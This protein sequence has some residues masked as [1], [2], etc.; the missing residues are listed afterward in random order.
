MTGPVHVFAHGWYGAGNVGDELLLDT[1]AR[2]TEEA[3]ATLSVASI[4]PAHT[5]RMHGL[6]AVHARDLAAV[7]RRM[8]ASD[9]VVLGG[10][11]LFQTHHAF[12]IAGLYSFGSGDIAAYARPA[13]MAAQWGLP[14]LLWAQG[15]GPLEG[16]QARRIVAHVASTAHAVS[17][18]DAESARLLREIGVARETVVAPDPVW[19]MP[20]GEAPPRNGSLQRLGL[21]IRPWPEPHWEA[22]LVEAL[23]AALDPAATTLA[24]IAFQTADSESDAP[25]IERLQARLPMFRHETV[26]VRE[27]DRAAAEIAACDALVCMRLHAQIL[28]LRLA[29]PLLCL[30]YDAKM[31]VTSELAGVPDA[32]RLTLDAPAAAWVAKMRGLGASMRSPAEPERLAR[33]SREA[34]HHREVLHRAIAD[35]AER[36][37]GRVWRESGFDWAAAWSCDASHHAIAQREGRIAALAELNG[38][39]ASEIARLE[40]SLAASRAEVDALRLDRDAV[41]ACALQLDDELQLLRAM[42]DELDACLARSRQ[43]ADAATM[44]RLAAE[45]EAAQLSQA[46]QATQESMSWRITHPLRVARGLLVLRG[47]ARRE[48]AISAARSLFWSL[49]G[50]LR[51][52]A[53]RVRRHRAQSRPAHARPAGFDWPAWANAGSRIAIVPSA[54]EFDELVNQRPI[55][56][57]KYLAARGVHVVFAAW[58]WRRDEVLQ[59]SGSEVYPGVMQVDLYDLL[60]RIGE[61]N[62]RADRESLYV[63]TLPAPDLVRLHAAARARGLAVVYDIL[64]DW[65]GFHA[66]GQAPWFDDAYEAEAVLAADV[67]A[68]VSPALAARFASLRGDIEVIGNGHTPALLGLE[69]RLCARRKAP[70]TR[71]RIGYFG[72]LTEA[73]FD[74]DVVLEAARRLPDMDFELIGYGE[75]EW[76]RAATAALPNVTLVGKVPPASLWRY[77]QQWDVALAPF[78]PGPLAECID[79]IKAYEYLYFGLPVVC[80]GIAHLA[81]FPGVRVVQGAQAFIEACT[82]LAEA[83]PDTAR[84]DA[85]LQQ[86]TWEARFDRLLALAAGRGLKD[87][88]VH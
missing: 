62:V 4:D 85:F 38:T 48:L 17:V 71:R 46:L 21:V 47:D 88:Y 22:A 64:D 73:W 31:A 26:T 16:D 18:R 1:L 10:G 27:L 39:Q 55:N 45:R 60:D 14:C 40:Q 74:W 34:L 3:G 72:H 82:A 57:A 19:A 28:A 23:H 7:A 81:E 83:P 44:A 52:L 35:A 8:S 80:T 70:A 87:L 56:L 63:L 33:L 32:L 84:L 86:T 51:R 30:E 24:W 42:R 37:P 49:P 2:W 54:F 20:L 58:Q 9:L 67:V 15:I 59:R 41:A 53:V 12:T 66:V 6:N 43:E 65:R 36:P 61:L 79:P 50:P 13:L 29:R 78:R 69:H 76:V 75:P 11:G 68:A 77:A 25:V 5:R